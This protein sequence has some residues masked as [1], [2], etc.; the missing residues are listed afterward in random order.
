MER[1]RKTIGITAVL[2]ASVMWA[3]EPIFAKLSYQVTDYLNTFA[4]RTIF[5][6]I[7]ILIY[8]LI[9]QRK[10]MLV[11]RK[12]L[13]SLVYLSLVSTLFADLLYIYALTRV[14]VINAVLLGHMQP[15]FIIIMGYVVLKQDRLTHY[16]YLG[17]G[18]MIVAGLFVTTRNLSNVCALRFGTIGD[19]YVLLA[20]CAWAT[21]AI[22]ARKYLR[23]L[24]AGI[25]AL[26][27][28]LFAGV[29]F[30]VYMMCTTG[31]EIVSVYQVLLGVVIGVGTILYY[32]G[33]RLIKAAQVSAVEL[34]TP[35]FAAALGYVVLQETLTVMQIIGF[36]FLL[37]GIL[38]LS[39]KEP[40]H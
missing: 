33:I 24:P 28:F 8:V 21:T 30:I 10:H 7:V 3:L 40:A 39:K 17:I 11:K 16:D 23:H 6:F 35:F 37:C 25:I 2:G 15:I 5:C 14:P 32:T 38:F 12:D 26:Y 27:R 36:V 31:I 9:T 34:S 19:L 13:P 20:T 29:I 22:V 1:N 4:L 18:S